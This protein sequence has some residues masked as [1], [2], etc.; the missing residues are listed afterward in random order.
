MN[1]GEHSTKCG[2]LCRSMQSLSEPMTAT[3]PFGPDDP[4]LQSL[5]RSQDDNDGRQPQ[6]AAIDWEEDCSQFHIGQIGREDPI[7]PG[8]ARMHQYGEEQA[9]GIRVDLRNE[10][11]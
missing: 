1:T 7:G 9:I 2:R 3:R 6:D 4:C 8:G 10:D 5:A 11:A